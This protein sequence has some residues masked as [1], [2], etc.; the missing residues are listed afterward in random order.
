MEK[1]TITAAQ[2]NLP[3][4]VKLVTEENKSYRIEVP[5]G[6]AVLVSSQVYESL[7]ETLELLSIPGFR[8]S[9]QESLRQ[10]ANQETYSLDEVLG[11]ID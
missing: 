6:S 10:V 9:L 3:S 8:E 11:D 2:E 5:N 7:Q 1:L 4:I